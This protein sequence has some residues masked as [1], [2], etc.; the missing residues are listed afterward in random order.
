MHRLPLRVWATPLTIGSSLLMAGTGVLMFFEW[1]RGV[2]VVVHQWFSWLFLTGVTAHVAVNARPFASHL[3]TRWG[4]A[5]VAT[6]VMVLAA[7]FVSWGT[8]TGPELERPIEQALVAAPLSALASVIK[9]DP[10]VLMR[11][12]R[13]HG[14]SATR[15]QSIRDVSVESA[16]GENR[17]LAIVYLPE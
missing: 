14:V 17:L 15:E 7:S 4:K 11:R 3:Q 5:S 10:E 8:I 1:D 2:T 16:V 12:L 6:F 13:A 9:T